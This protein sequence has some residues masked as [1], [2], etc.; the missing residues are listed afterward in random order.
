MPIEDYLV[1]GATGQEVDLFIDFA[2]S[3]GWNPGIHDAKAFFAADPKG[4]F[5]GVFNGKPAASISAVAYGSTFGFL[6]FYIVQPHL[7][8]RGLGIKVWNAAMEHLRGRN[9]G[10]DS[11]LGQQKLYERDGFRPYYK[12][13]R[14]EGVGTGRR[15]WADG[16]KYLSNVPFEDLLAYDDRYFPA[17]RHSFV[18]SWISQPGV[19]GLGAM[20]GGELE[21]YGVI[22]QCHQ[23]Y[24]IGPLFA[25]NADV[26]ESLFCGLCD[27]A[28]AGAPVFLDTPEPNSAAL[29][30]AGRH[31]MHPAFETVRM[32]N[33][34]DPFL[35]LEGIFG[36]TSFELG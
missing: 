28:P 24:K 5:V 16:I 12:S 21:G 31:N 3:E 36:V 18:K 20:S 35:P 1:R 32:Y 10:L 33:K 15:R 29:E 34:G 26:A 4:F 7:R 19:V 14:H 11:V 25:D 9:I 2:N 23:G 27:H 13:I 8:G 17:P 22:R 30:L 6:G